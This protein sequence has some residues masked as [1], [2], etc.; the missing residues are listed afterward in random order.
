MEMLAQCR[1]HTGL[2]IDPDAIQRLSRVF[3]LHI[4][5]ILADLYND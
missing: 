2:H 5:N 4:A 3:N 1:Q